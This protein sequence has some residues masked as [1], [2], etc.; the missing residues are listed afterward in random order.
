MVWD[1]ETYDE[2]RK[3]LVPDF[4]AFYST[5]AQVVARQ[6]SRKLK[7]LDLGAG[8]G[9]LS[10]HVINMCPQ[11]S[12]TLLDASE[13]MLAIAK[14]RLAGHDTSFVYS[15]LE[16]PLP[17]AT[18]DAVV[19]AVSIHHLEDDE[20]EQL[21]ARVFA[22]LEPGGIF[23]NADQYA[24]PS[25]QHDGI[26]REMHESQARALGSNDDE[27]AA[28]VERMRIDRYASIEWHRASWSHL[29]FVGFDCFFKRFGFAVLAG[30]KEH[31]G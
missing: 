30:W 1:P 11:A 5:A 22:C 9:I 21:F 29:G 13:E 20:K 31:L 10:D 3:R 19:S 17:N 6:H 12:L 27:W 15:R 25:P 4:D 16:D 14:Q 2:S 28:A 8:T 7:V 23:V 24:G 18:F 26:Y